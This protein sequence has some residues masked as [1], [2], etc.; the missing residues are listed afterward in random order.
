MKK[1]LWILAIVFLPLF[2]ISCDEE[3]AHDPLNTFT[4]YKTAFAAL[5]FA[6]M[7]K[8]LDAKSKEKMTEE[9]Y[10]K[11]YQ[12]IYDSIPVT[13]AKME[14]RMDELDLYKKIED[15]NEVRVPVNMSIIGEDLNQ[16]YSVDVKLVKEVDEAAGNSNFKVSF[17]YNL[18]YEG[19]QSTDKV[20]FEETLPERGRILDRNLKPIADNAELLWIGMVPGKLG[21]DRNAAIAALSDAFGLTPAFISKRLGLSWAKENTFVDMIKVPSSEKE[22]VDA[23]TSKY[24]GIIY[25]TLTDRTY[26]YGEVAAHLTGY[27]GL[28]NKEEYKELQPLGFPINTKVGR[29]GLEMIYEKEL[30]G[31]KGV[32][33]VLL[34]K[35]DHVKKVLGHNKSN[36]GKDIVLTIDIDKQVNLFNAIGGEIGTASLVNYKTGEIEALVSSPSYDPNEFIIGQSQASYDALIR[37]PKNPLL[38]RFSKLYVPGS[39]LKPI[40]TGLALDLI[41][42]DEKF[43]MNVQGLSWQKD[44][45]WGN[46]FVKRISEPSNPV[47]LEKAFIYSDNT[48]F[49]QMALNLGETNFIEGA[50]KYGLGSDIGIGYPLETSQLA[51]N[52]VMNNEILLAD[53]GYG[54]GQVLVNIL[55]LPKAFTVFANGGNLIDLKLIKDD[56]NPIATNVTTPEIAEKVFSL[57]KSSVDSSEGT[58][59][60]AYIEGR[61]LGGK[62]GTAQVGNLELGWFSVIDKNDN[63]PFITTM[64]IEGVQ[65]RGGSSITVDKVKAFLGTY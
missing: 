40:T 17:A 56:Q 63:S 30:R 42:F 24:P 22:K 26:P 52:G 9:D 32:Q 53:S 55:T 39:V 27:L 59:H 25:R 11:M 47:N 12:N 46:Y 2:M 19:L 45:S 48:Y 4:E 51:N 28:V 43:E 36:Q 35:D 64:M 6:A 8:N 10:V 58:A 21:A 41:K 62:T 50:K 1:L 38:N 7:Y 49:A 54:Q 34:D 14:S 29:A 3:V 57:M 31:T 61:N 5:D 60:G 33:A 13:E 18:V 44:A 16:S 20:I 37:N 65:K 23:M 15:K